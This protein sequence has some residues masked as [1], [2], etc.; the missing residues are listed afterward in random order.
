[1]FRSNCPLPDRPWLAALLIPLLLAACR[2]AEQAPVE[3]Q[4][5]ELDE[6]R[7]E[8][9]RPIA[10]PDTEG[11]RWTVSANGQAIGFAAEGQAPW[12][13]LECR[14]KDHPPQVTI[15]RHAPARPGEKALFPVIGNGTIARFKLDAA[16]TDGEWRWQ[17]AVPADDALLE[18]FTGA[19]ALEATL[20]GAGSL[21]IEGSRIPGQFIAWCRAGGA[22]A[23]AVGEEQAEE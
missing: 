12:L 11:A 8:A 17:G 5:I 21:L 2:Q 6:V 3:G 15:I 22:V 1:M 9:R 23:A 14:L 7:K 13:T 16:L 18:V 4:R 10:S 20:P 19:R